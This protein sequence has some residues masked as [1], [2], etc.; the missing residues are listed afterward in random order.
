ML[1]C[2]PKT[3]SCPALQARS[4]CRGGLM[5]SCVKACVAV[6]AMSIEGAQLTLSDLP[7]LPKPQRRKQAF[8]AILGA[9]TVLLT[10]G[11]SIGCALWS[12]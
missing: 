2:N 10:C 4:V 8:G 5:L 11:G 12:V 6:R 3:T 1:A 9:V 7:A